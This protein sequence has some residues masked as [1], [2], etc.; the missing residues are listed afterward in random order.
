[1]ESR[2]GKIKLDVEIFDPN[3]LA[4]SHLTSSN[5][6]DFKEFECEDLGAV[7]TDSNSSSEG[8]TSYKS[9]YFEHKNDLFDCIK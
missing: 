9:E 8:K 6:D 2:K 5:K 3:T 1:M 7:P 4:S